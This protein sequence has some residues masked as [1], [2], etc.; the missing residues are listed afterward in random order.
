MTENIETKFWKANF[1]TLWHKLFWYVIKFG[2]IGGIGFIIDISIFN[3]LRINFLE[4]NYW[5]ATALGAKTVST[6]IAIIFNWVGNRYW[7]FREHRSTKLLQEFTEYLIAS[8]L[9][10]GV[11]LITL[12]F[13]H[14]VLGFTSLFADN[15]SANIVGLILGTLLRFVLYRFWVWKPAVS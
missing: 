5:W 8:L 14:Y 15:I 12:G 6:S 9:G 7:T 1:E 13:S 2:I 4:T 10:L 3:F 11:A